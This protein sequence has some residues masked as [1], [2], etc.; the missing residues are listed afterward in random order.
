MPDE[1]TVVLLLILGAGAIGGNDLVSV[2]AAVMLILQLVGM[3]DVFQFLDTHGVQIG[4]IFLMLGLLLPFASSKM[5]L[6]ETARSLL[7]PVGLLAVLFGV[8]AAYFA[9]QGVSML[10]HHPEMLIGLVVGSVIGVQYFGG[11]PAGPLVA[12]GMAALVYKLFR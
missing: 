5:G 2:S 1:G 7:S 11:I 3:T 12:A 8:G 10:Q 6:S 9:A 4:V